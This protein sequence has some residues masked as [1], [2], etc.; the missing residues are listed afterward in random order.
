MMPS[1]NNLHPHHS[2]DGGPTKHLSLRANERVRVDCC[3][4]CMLQLFFA[5]I[6]GACIWFKLSWLSASPVTELIDKSD[7]SPRN[8]WRNGFLGGGLRRSLAFS[9]LRGHITTGSYNHDD[10]SKFVFV[11]HVMPH[12]VGKFELEPGYIAVNLPWVTLSMLMTKAE[13][14][15][16]AQRHGVKVPARMTSQAGIMMMNEHKCDTG[17]CRELI[18]LFTPVPKPASKIHNDVKERVF[19]PRPSTDMLKEEIIA[20]FC[21]DSAPSEFMEAGCKVCGQ[22]THLKDLM[23]TA[24]CEFDETILENPTVT[25]K[26]RSSIEQPV[27]QETGPIYAK[28]CTQICESCAKSLLKGKR[29][30]MALANGFWVGEVPEALKGLTF[31][32]KMMIAKVRHN[33]CVVRVASGRGKLAANA[34]MFSNPTLKVYNKLP[35]SRDELSEVLAFVF[36]GPTKPTEDLYSRTPML[37]RRNNVAAA[38]EWL[39][40]NHENYAELQI[41]QEN[42]DSYDLNGVPVTVNWQQSAEGESENP[43]SKSV[44]EPD[45]DNEEEGTEVGACSFRIHGLTGEEHDHMS[46]DALKSRALNHMNRGGKALG[47]GHDDKPQSTYDNPAAYPSMFPWLFPYGKGGFGN[48]G[49]ETRISELTHKHHLLMHH[50][51]RFQTDLYF[52]LVAFNHD[53][54]KCG[55]TGSFLLAKRRKFDSIAER[56]LT[57]NSTVLS[58]LSERMARGDNVSANTEEE[59]KCFDILNDIDHVGGH[60]KGSITSKKYMRNEIWALVNHLGAPSWFITFSPADV[61]HP[62]CLYYAGSDIKFSPEI[63]L[64]DE[65]QRLIAANPVA[66]ARFFDFMVKLFVKHVL[67]VGVKHEGLYGDTSAYYGTVEQQGRLTLHLHMLVWI[68]D[69][70]S[71]QEI[72]DRLCDKSATSLFKDQLISY[73]EAAHTGDF[74]TGSMEDVKKHLPKYV[75]ERKPGIHDLIDE[76]STSLPLDTATLNYKDPTQTMPEA[77]PTGLCTCL[78]D[79]SQ[80]HHC[81]TLHE[82]RAQFKLTVDDILLRSNVHTCQDTREVKGLRQP[83]KATQKN[84]SFAKGCLNK[85]GICTARFPR[86]Q[87]LETHIDPDGT[88]NLK[89]IETMI[90]TITAV[91]TFLYRCNS[92]VASLLSG[93]AIKAVIAYVTNYV[94]KMALKAHH[95]FASMVAILNRNTQTI[96]DS[97]K[98]RHENA[99]KLILQIVNSLTSKMEIGSPMASLYLLGN[100]DHYT[101]HTFKVFWWKSY[102]SAVMRSWTENEEDHAEEDVMLDKEGNEFIAFSNVDDYVFRPSMFDDMCLT[103]WIQTSSKRRLTKRERQVEDSEVAVPAGWSRFE[104]G[105]V[106]ENSHIVKCDKKL[107]DTVVPNYAGGSVPRRDQGDREY[108]CTTMLTMFAPWRTGR[109]LKECGETWEDA[110]TKYPFHAWQKRKMENF[111]LKYECLDARDDYYAIQKQKSE[112]ANRQNFRSKLNLFMGDDDNS[113]NDMEDIEFEVSEDTVGDVDVLG[114]DHLR[115]LQH[116]KEAKQLMIS[117]GWLQ[118]ALEKKVDVVEHF[119]PDVDLSPAQWRKTVA[120]VRAR[121]MEIKVRNLPPSVA[122]VMHAIRQ[123][124]INR[125]EVLDPRHILNPSYKKDIARAK[126]VKETVCSQFHLNA[127]QERAF[128]LIADHASELQDKQL[129]MYLGGMGGTGKSQVIKALTEFFNIRDEGHRFIILAPTGTA[130]ALLGG[131]TYHSLLGLGGKRGDEPNMPTAGLRQVEAKLMGVEYIFIDE[132]SMLSY[133]NMYSISERLASARSEPTQPFGGINM[134]FAGDFAQL[135]PVG[136]RSLFREPPSIVARMSLMAQKEIIGRVLWHQV[137]TVVILKKNMRQQNESTEDNAFRICLENMRYGA[138]TEK[139][140]KFLRRHVVGPASQGPQLTDPKFRDVAIITAWNAQKD[141]INEMGSTR[142]AKDSGQT[143]TDFHSVDSLGPATDGPSKTKGRPQKKRMAATSALARR[144]KESLWDCHPSMSNQL[145]G[146]LRLCIGMP[147]MIRI[148]D[149]TELCITKGQ[150]GVVVGWDSGIGPDEVEILNT[151]FVKLKDPPSEV[152]IDGLPT[153]VVPMPRVAEAIICTLPN[154]AEITIKRQQVRVLPFFAMTDYASQGKNRPHN[155]VDLTKCKNHFSYY[156]CLSRSTTAEGTAILEGMNVSLVTKGIS[157]FLRQEFRE[158]E[159]LNEITKAEFEGVLEHIVTGDHRNERLRTYQMAKGENYD[160]QD[161]HASLKW[162]EID[163]PRMPRYEKAGAWKIVGAKGQVKTGPKKAN[164][165]QI[166]KVSVEVKVSP[167]SKIT[168]KR[169][170]QHDTG[171]LTVKKRRTTLEVGVST[172]T[173]KGI[174]WDAENYSCA[175]DSVFTVLWNLWIEDADK[176]TDIFNYTSGCL[177]HL[178]NQFAAVREGQQSLETARDKVRIFLHA[179]DGN[180]FPYGREWSSLDMLA[181]KTF[182]SFASGNIIRLCSQCDHRVDTNRRT[183]AGTMYLTPRDGNA[184]RYLVSQWFEKSFARRESNESCTNCGTRCQLKTEVMQVPNLLALMIY[185]DLLDF[186]PLLT[187][188]TVWGEKLIL[189]LTGIIY[190]GGSHFTSRYIDGSENVWYHDGIQT[191]DQTHKELLP[192]DL[193]L[194]GGRK[195]ALVIYARVA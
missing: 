31:A 84:V 73:L 61:K 117:A 142:F 1:F 160:P 59:K 16:I 126:E 136:G 75:G 88:V 98:G 169:Q 32:E 34:I 37:V 49:I 185:D 147:V 111:N 74:L 104:A 15:H 186:D 19:P 132:V 76:S 164:E 47:I 7:V 182:A 56:L 53:Q 125:V 96:G 148:N 8:A 41:S 112:T 177:W 83:Q 12:E 89:K 163:A 64:S 81:A 93:T 151:L 79:N 44:H 193:K 108:Y 71:P 118:P 58:D 124:D 62:I 107:M 101:G 156:T 162:T 152:N 195:A 123:Q 21:A 184:D 150:E 42:L 57:V 181:D 66:A 20:G 176:W 100:P 138:C 159:L 187:F 97:G 190:S 188:T 46:T 161:L 29:P 94:T 192:V 171:Q 146:K 65:R 189:R 137:T 13:V 145:A 95:V 6:V 143:L 99:R 26:E 167:E 172:R 175:Y 120:E 2:V 194:A 165:P 91:V 35:P 191:G 4:Q 127:D 115:R 144:I 128:R 153:N 179:L 92:D 54:I 183:L 23:N 22:L 87:V 40:L 77:P 110:F 155:V 63:K 68:K 18:S 24:N 78:D 3:W 133:H 140:I 86:E 106:H 178:A 174:K 9:V 180:A 139:D 33:R 67:G 82:W 72:R 114:N 36:I 121:A 10:D 157:G 5:C 70:M 134:I 43:L 122:G 158:L 90:N 39:K 141:M 149:A 130:A 129:K 48:S 28:T 27:A 119:K 113:R 45:N 38:L 116:M 154:D 17:P 109:D 30:A 51:K 60:V 25:R 52:P 102:T 135:P 69:S 14:R 173:L 170:V 11:A 55:T 166:E 103:E 131:S 168:S 85:D 105:H 80:C 50:D